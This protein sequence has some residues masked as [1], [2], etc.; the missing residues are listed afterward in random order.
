MASDPDNGNIES[1]FILLCSIE[2]HKKASPQ[3]SFSEF[4]VNSWYAET[5]ESFTES[6]ISLYPN[7]VLHK[8]LRILL[9][10]YA[11]AYFFCWVKTQ[12]VSRFSIC[13]KC[14]DSEV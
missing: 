3:N 2:V 14:P 1:K 4:W 7:A 8:C 10:V 12:D 13:F 6:V 11:N 5:A 9:T